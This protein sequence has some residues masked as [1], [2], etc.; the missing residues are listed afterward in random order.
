MPTAT[1]N[2]TYE[3]YSFGCVD[4][5]LKNIWGFFTN[6][7]REAF[8]AAHLVK[9]QTGAAFWKPGKPIRANFSTETQF[10]FEASFQYDYV[11]ITNRSN[12]NNQKMVYYAFIIEHVYLN[13]NLT[14]LV[15]DIDWIQTY[16]FNATTPWFNRQC[17]C[18]YTN[19]PYVL[20]MRGTASD[21]PIPARVSL[22][23]LSPG[24]KTQTS[25]A[26]DGLILINQ[27]LKMQVV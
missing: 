22:P 20:P 14:E 26:L 17:Y 8:L 18:A 24:W 11:R 5:T 27:T 4:P 16:Y 13:A 23:R 10:S 2:T 21:L 12:D 1:R 9:T 19:S 7:E 25:T 15:L 6:A 3:F